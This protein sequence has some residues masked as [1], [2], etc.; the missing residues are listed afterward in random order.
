MF[1]WA[2]GGG[3]AAH[4]QAAATQLQGLNMKVP[5]AKLKNDSTENK[6]G[7]YQHAEADSMKF[8]QLRKDD[9]Y[10]KADTATNA[11]KKDTLKHYDT[12]IIPQGEN[13][14]HSFSM[15]RFSNTN[16][17]LA[18]NEQQINQKLAAL[19]RQINQPQPTVQQAADVQ[20][21]N[22]NTEAELSALK[23]QMQ[24]MNNSNAGDPQM[25]QL[26]GMLDKIQ[27]IQ[28]PS[29]VRQK[30]K[31]Q[32]EKERGTVLPVSSSINT[33]D[34]SIMGGTMD[35]SGY[36]AGY[37]TAQ[38]QNGFYDLDQPNQDEQ[39]NAVTAVVHETQTL[40]AGS[41]IK[42]RLLQDIF[43]N[44]RLIPKETFVFGTCSIEGERLTVDIKT[45]GYHNSVYPVAMKVFDRDGLSGI[46]VPGA[47]ARD[48]AKDGTDQ[49]IQ[50]YDPM[51][52]DPSLG[53]QAATAGITM[54]K[55]FFS[56]KVK[57]VKVTVKAGYAVLLVNGNQ[58]NK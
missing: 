24:K 32:S 25:Q 27:E 48:A 47:I 23:A 18:E 46:Y 58:L 29:L 1:F 53:A 55:G 2:M 56:K 34:A 45:I 50:N 35:T 22:D 40:T 21:G 51:S 39:G 49:A 15:R 52:Y 26:N 43:I 54:A 13:I 19:N 7:F 37:N 36:R 38:Q 10:Y 8:K 12:G 28:N 5:G 44:G 41:T 30:L 16:A 57:L 9:P 14:G 4:A 31:A 42:L 20:H 17:N 11:V 33:G 3:K 6:L